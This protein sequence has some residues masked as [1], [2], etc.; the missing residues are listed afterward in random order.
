MSRPTREQKRQEHQDRKDAR[1]AA[2]ADLEAER[3]AGVWTESVNYKNER[4][5]RDS[6]Q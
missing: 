3:K 1:A 5:S 4:S 6:G 2:R